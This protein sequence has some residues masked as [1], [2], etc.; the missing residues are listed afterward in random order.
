MYV[1]VTETVQNIPLDDDSMG[2]HKERKITF[3]FHV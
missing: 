1:K 3:V 2:Y